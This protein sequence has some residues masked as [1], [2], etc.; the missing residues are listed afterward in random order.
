MKLT[1][2]APILSPIKNPVRNGLIRKGVQ[3]PFKSDALFWLDGTISGD[4]FVD[5]SGNNRNFTITNKDFDSDWTKGFPYKSAATISAPAGDA[6]LIAADINNF[7][8]DSGG[9]PNEIPVVS[10]FQDIDYENKLFCRH[11]AQIVDVN[12]VEIY[13]PRVLDIVLYNTIKTGADL[14]KCQSYFSVPTKLTAKWVDPDGLDTN[15]GTEANP[16]LTIV[17]GYTTAGIGGLSYVKSKEYTEYIYNLSRNSIKAIGLVDYVSTDGSY[18]ARLRYADIP[19][20]EGFILRA[21][22]IATASINGQNAETLELKRLYIESNATIG[23]V[24]DH[25]LIQNVIFKGTNTFN[26]SNTGSTQSRIVDT[27]FFKSTASSLIYIPNGLGKITVKNCKIDAIS[28]TFITFL[29]TLA[30][31]DIIGNLIEIATPSNY[32]NSDGDLGLV[33]ILYNIF[34][35]KKGTSQTIKITDHVT[36]PPIIKNN[37]FNINDDVEE[38]IVY[39][40]NS[41]ID[42]ENNIFTLNGEPEAYAEIQSLTGTDIVYP[43]FKAINNRIESKRKGGYNI[44]V[45]GESTSPADNDIALIEIKNNYIKSRHA[46]ALPTTNGTHSKF[47]GFQIN[48]DIKYNFTWGAGYSAVIKGST[49][50]VYTSNGFTYNVEKEF[51]RGVY[52][53]GSQSVPIY[54]NT[55]FSNDVDPDYAVRLAENVGSDASSNCKI[56]NNIFI[57]LGTGTYQPIQILNGGTGNESDYNLFYCP[58]GTLQFQNAN[59]VRTFAQWQSDGFDEHSHVLTDEEF[60]NLFTDYENDDFSINIMP[61]NGVYLSDYK[62]GLD[63][64]TDWG[65]SDTVPSV[66]TKDQDENNVTIGVYIE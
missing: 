30:G 63:A 55:F 21:A 50:T 17:K 60:N 49:G 44:G 27:C 37:I 39:A 20:F 56:K 47:V 43:C 65:D 8:Y 53:K 40:A 48:A 12:N 41:A 16:Y 25:K 26:I 23:I 1:D 19:L 58:N 3:I 38:S 6:T 66:V 64:S 4:E 13:E 33:Q 61:Y 52:C 51:L 46:Y 10:L 18:G 14:T 24:G 29:N 36:N 7:L 31:L 57:Y 28:G 59:G 11:A 9:T 54:N 42:V 45:G 22:S 15:L 34:N 5:K 32:I 62:T 35:V 2:Q